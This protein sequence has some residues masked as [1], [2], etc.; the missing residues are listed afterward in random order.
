MK[1][2][3]SISITDEN[4]S[5]ESKEP[6][7]NFKGSVKALFGNGPWVIVLLLSF[8]NFLRLALT[9]SSITYY[10]V[11][12][13]KVDETQSA[14]FS[15][16]GVVAALVLLPFASK[17]VDKF[18]YNKTLVSSFIAIAVFGFM[19]YFS[20]RNIMLVLIFYLLFTAAGSLPHVAVLAMLA[21]TLEYGEAKYGLRLE[22]LGFAAN[23]FAGKVAPAMGALLVTVI[24]SVG[25]LDT[26]LS[27][28]QEQSS[29]GIM[30]LRLTMFL[31]P[32]VIAIIQVVLAHVYPLNRTKMEEIYK[33]IIKNNIN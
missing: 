21:D 1:K 29:S 19:A 25:G 31:I 6:K 11:Y 3:S 28:G 15:S 33:K 22:G 4:V 16:L 10:F 8:L 7:M 23:S 18:G 32:N 5:L 13:F 17:I 30:A 12:Y 20:E 26:T 9:N 14:I 27:M 2:E 24:F